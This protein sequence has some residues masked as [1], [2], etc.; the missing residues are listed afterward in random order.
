MPSA[1]QPGNW[2]P[3]HPVPELPSEGEPGLPALEQAHHDDE[4]RRQRVTV[5]AEINVTPLVDVVLVLLIIFMVVA[6]QLE[7][8]ASVDLPQARHPDAENKSLEPLTV[9]LTRTGE[10]FI[11]RER[12]GRDELREHLERARRERPDAKVVVKADRAAPYGEVRALFKTCQALEFPGASM[13]V[14][15]VTQR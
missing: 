15:A 7:A 6:P 13:Q 4:P 3:G 8:G 14:A 11:D 2:G 1:E 12:V 5:R 9:S 10:L